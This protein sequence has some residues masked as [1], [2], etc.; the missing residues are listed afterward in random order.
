MLASM[1]M[2]MPPWI[3][4]ACWPMKRPDRPIC[5]F[6]ADMAWRRSRTSLVRRHHGR[7]HG[8]AARLLERDQHVGG[9]VLQHLEAAD[10][11][12]ELLA[13]L[14]VVDGEF[15]HRCHGADRFGA[16]RRHRHIGDLFD[17]REGRAGLAD[18]P[19][20]VRTLFNDSSAARRPSTVA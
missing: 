18:R 8:H 6:A 17:Q 10:G 11:N 20:S 15:V 13:R 16:N 12:A 14:H 5:T 1:V 2:P 19:A 7:Q 9:A 4:I 3:W